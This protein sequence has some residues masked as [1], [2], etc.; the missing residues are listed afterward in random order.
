MRKLFIWRLE[1]SGNAVVTSIIVIGIFTTVNYLFP[2]AYRSKYRGLV[3]SAVYPSCDQTWTDNLLLCPEMIG[4]LGNTMFEYASAYGIA[5]DVNRT[6]VLPEDDKL[7][8]MFHITAKAVYNRTFTC[9]RWKHERIEFAGIW[10]KLIYDKVRKSPENVMLRHYFQ[11]WKFFEKYKKEIKNE[12]SLK[13]SIQYAANEILRDIATKFYPGGTRV[14]FIGVHI[15]R[16]DYLTR[17][18]ASFGY[19]IAPTNYVIRAIQYC[20]SKYTNAMFVVC[21]EDVEETRHE[22]KPLNDAQIE[23]VFHE[24]SPEVDFG[25]LVACNHTIMTVGSFGWW[26]GYLAGGDVI[27]FKYPVKDHTKARHQFDTNFSDYFHPDW[28]GME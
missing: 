17:R 28:I 2:V 19:N 25:L 21:S 20:L 13:R 1:N 4:R 5:K 23:I 9:E 22:L 15:R 8:Q 12:F 26:A 3:M 6:L 11:S 18:F 24:R 7:W 10:E 16:G 14:T 27:Y